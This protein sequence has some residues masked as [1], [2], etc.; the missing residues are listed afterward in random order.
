MQTIF[1][2]A[3]TDSDKA[4]RRRLLHIILLATTASG[5]ITLVA[6]MVV[7]PSGIGSEQD[8]RLLRLT[9]VGVIL[10]STIIYAVSLYVSTELA[11]V[12]F[13]LS[14]L[15]L[16]VLSDVPHEVANG[17]GLL[18][19]ALPIVGA[20]V[21]VKPW[22]SFAAAG[23]ASLAVVALETAVLGNPVP[24]LPAIATFFLLA[25]LSWLSAAA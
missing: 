25:L 9:A 18:V 3:I 20:S 19:F 2:T 14:L 8:H 24:N 6:L 5:I 17:R 11:G 4:R 16:A 21:L 15:A 7:S 23:I 1:E 22:A 12:A 10:G 13:I